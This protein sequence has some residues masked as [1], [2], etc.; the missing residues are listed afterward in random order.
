MDLRNNLSLVTSDVQLGNIDAA[1]ALLCVDIIDLTERAEALDL[2]CVVD[3]L[4]RASNFCLR[5]A[6]D[7]KS[8]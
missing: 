7:S 2:D 1:V 4:N 3:L 8:T 6:P 5:K